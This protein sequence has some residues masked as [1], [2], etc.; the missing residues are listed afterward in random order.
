[1][2]LTSLLRLRGV[3][4]IGGSALLLSTLVAGGCGRVGLELLPADAGVEEDAGTVEMDGGA[5]DAG[6][7]MDGTLRDAGNDLVDGC[8]LSETGECLACIG[9]DAYVPTTS[10]GVGYC[11]TSGS[12]S[13]CIDGI[14]LA[15][16]TGGPRALTDSTC[17]GVDDDCDG[18]ADEEYLPTANN[19]GSGVCARNGT[20][21]CMAG[22]TQDTCVPGKPMTSLDDAT[23]TGNG[24]DDDCDG[25][26]DEDVSSCSNTKP[27]PY[28]A[29]IYMNI[30]VPSG[31]GSANVQLWGGAGA[32]G[33]ENGIGSSVEPGGRGGSGGYARGTLVL[34]GPLTLYV[35]NGGT[36]NANINDCPGANGAGG[37]N[38]GSASY[39]GGRGG[40]GNGASGGDGM[41]AGGG[42]GAS[43]TFGD[44][45]GRGYF[46]GGGGGQSS[47][48]PVNGLFSGGGGGGAATVA[49]LNG[50]RV[51]VAG[52][53]GG[54]GGAATLVYN[55]GE[56][57]GN[58]G[59]GCSGSGTA[60]TSPRTGGGGGGG[61]CVGMTTSAGTN[62]LPANADLV[63]AP[64][65]RGTNMKCR[66]GGNGYAI[67]TFAR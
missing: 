52:G 57:G 65:A 21:T 34:T 56:A 49:L 48:D 32:A 11:A 26:V 61:V 38:P 53:G 22:G 51:L 16:V 29:G 20:L 42:S 35:G 37:T 55:F 36:A 39:S 30:P 7:E 12:P 27:I 41:V 19:C 3:P 9:G 40:S 43:N 33:N 13:M 50:M 17:D 64:N 66:P 54:G 44:S 28:V 18:I 45:G 58:G 46:G 60:G 47:A 24:L 1:V 25:Q 2:S 8:V 10:C 5:S 31:C 67:V 14:E 23:G 62:G 15:C 6:D 59:E 63:P 4:H